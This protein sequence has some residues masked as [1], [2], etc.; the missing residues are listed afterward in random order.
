MS[1]KFILLIVF[2][3]LLAFGGYFLYTKLFLNEITVG[4]GSVKKIETNFETGFFSSQKFLG[5]KDHLADPLV[6][7]ERG[8]I[9]PFMKF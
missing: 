5:L 2:L 9:N 7:G 3:V 1:K 4:L 8:K 6:A